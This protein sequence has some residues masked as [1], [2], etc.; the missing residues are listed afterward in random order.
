[1][2]AKLAAVRLLASHLLVRKGVS[3]VQEIRSHLTITAD[4]N[5]RDPFLVNCWSLMSEKGAG[6]CRR[7]RAVT[8][9]PMN[10]ASSHIL[11]QGR[12]EATYIAAL[13]IQ[14]APMEFQR[15]TA[16]LTDSAELFIGEGARSAVCNNREPVLWNVWLT[17]GFHSTS[18][19]IS[20]Y[21]ENRP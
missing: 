8:Q 16:Q 9:C 5:S 15:E 21:N 18:S 7:R 6:A 17:T 12:I 20:R 1:M 19:V 10:L 13:H 4:W 2:E 11:N 14:E 3:S